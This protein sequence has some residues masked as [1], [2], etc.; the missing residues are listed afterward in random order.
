M[1][2]AAR[3]GAGDGIARLKRAAGQ[4]LFRQFGRH[5]TGNGQLTQCRVIIL[6]EKLQKLCFSKLA[7]FSDLSVS[8]SSRRRPNRKKTLFSEHNQ[9]CE[10]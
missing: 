7:D 1:A 5:L 4:G 9:I 8:V 10:A 3:S 2:G 6:S